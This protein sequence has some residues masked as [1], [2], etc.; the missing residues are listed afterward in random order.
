M[1]HRP[2]PARASSAIP[3]QPLREPLDPVKQAGIIRDTHMERCARGCRPGSPYCEVGLII[4][5]TY[6]WFAT[7]DF[8]SEARHT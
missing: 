5:A 4:Q 3:T 6:E 7:H 2:W 1:K 8:P